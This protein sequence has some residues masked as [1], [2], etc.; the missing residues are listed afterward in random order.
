MG[1]FT[2]HV[3]FAFKDDKRISCHFLLFRSICRYVVVHDNSYLGF[4]Q[5]KIHWLNMKDYAYPLNG[6]K[7]AKLPLEIS[8]IHVVVQACNEKGFESVALDLRVVLGFVCLHALVSTLL[9]T[10]GFKYI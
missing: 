10:Q 8:L 1:S 3:L 7:P 4:S 5:R 6:A 2:L 9:A